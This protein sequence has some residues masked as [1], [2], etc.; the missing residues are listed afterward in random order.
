MR[1]NK[2]ETRKGLQLK[3]HINKQ[4]VTFIE[5]RTTSTPSLKYHSLQ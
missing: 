4:I 5:T 2:A 3:A 1:K